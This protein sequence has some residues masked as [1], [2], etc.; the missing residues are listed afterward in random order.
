MGG[1]RFGDDGGSF[2]GDGEYWGHE[3]VCA[4]TDFDYGGDAVNGDDDVFTMIYT[5]LLVIRM[6]INFLY[7]Q[8][9]KCKQFLL[10]QIVTDVAGL[11]IFKNKNV[12]ITIHLPGK[13]CNFVTPRCCIQSPQR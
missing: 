7:F 1:G 10:R 4:C 11:I 13:W 9:Y 3:D 8:I 2:D 5:T 6:P 12:N